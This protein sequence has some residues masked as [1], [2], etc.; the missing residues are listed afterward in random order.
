MRTFALTFSA[1]VAFA[2]N[3]VLCRHAL[4]EEAIGPAGFTIV[5]LVSGAL[6]LAILYRFRGDHS[7]MEREAETGAQ[8]FLPPLY[9][10]TYAIAFSFAYVSLDAGVGA[11][12]LFL[13]VQAAILVAN[14]IQGNRLTPAEFGG[15]LL[16]LAGFVYLVY[17]SLTTPSIAGFALMVLSGVGWGMYTLAGKHSSDPLYTTSLN[18]RGSVPL[19]LLI[20]PFW[21]LERESTAAGIGLAALSG[22]FASGLGYTLWYAALPAL[23]NVQ[24]ASV[25]LLVPVLAAGGGT[26]LLGEAFTPRFVLSAVTILLGIFVVVRSRGANA[27]LSEV[28]R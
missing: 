22:G 3:S 11:L 21:F 6:V 1:L 5:R 17:P 8:R 16:A 19:V 12:V 9:L 18:F 13:S 27:A 2:A 28:G 4:R 24:A 14:R 23:G 10:A 15:A 7:A 26:L 20:L 25:Q